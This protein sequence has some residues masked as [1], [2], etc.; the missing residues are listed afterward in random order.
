MTLYPDGLDNGF[1]GNMVAREASSYHYAQLTGTEDFDYNDYKNVVNTAINT[2]IPKKYS[3][4]VRDEYGRAVLDCSSFVGL[5]LRGIPYKNSPFIT[6]TG[7]WERWVP[8]DELKGM[9]GSE[10]WEFRVI[11]NQP[12][13]EYKNMGF[14][15]YSSLRGAGHFA[16][17][18]YKYGYV[19][20]DFTRDGK[21][22]EE[23]KNIVKPGDIIFFSY[24]DDNGNLISSRR[25]ANTF[26]AIHHIG[27]AAERPGFWFHCTG[28]MGNGADEDEKGI[29]YAEWS[30]FLDS[31][32]LICRPNY[33]HGGLSAETP[34]G[35]NLLGFPW[36]SKVLYLTSYGIR[37]T[38]S[39]DEG[40]QLTITGQRTGTG[41][42]NTLTLVGDATNKNEALRLSNG[43]YRV[44]GIKDIAAEGVDLR[45]RKYDGAWVELA[46][47]TATADG[48]FSLDNDTGYTDVYVDLV[49][50]STEVLNYTVL[51][52]LV[53][54]K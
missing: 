22:T 12:A 30:T 7:A 51:P 40:N 18:F 11:D 6:H 42:S 44:F 43:S 5:V 50:R 21:A 41:A 3:A 19:V 46:R 47:S 25:D 36:R 27:I 39:G 2:A 20:Y 16:E 48:T 38:A 37:A 45:V 15:G 23:L 24:F 54:T 33:M 1:I 32:S 8:F 49:I 31:I 17:F 9:Y 53:R 10:G 29:V 34:I 52:S 14:E 13:G 28:D 26:K 4:C 35:I